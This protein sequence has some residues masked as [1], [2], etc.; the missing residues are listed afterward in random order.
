MIK[1][2][3]LSY[4]YLSSDF[5]YEICEIFSKVLGFRKLDAHNLTRY[6]NFEEE[7]LLFQQNQ[8]LAIPYQGLEYS[9]EDYRKRI[10]L[11]TETVNEDLLAGYEENRI[12]H[13]TENFFTKAFP[14]LEKL[15]GVAWINIGASHTTNLTASLYNQMVEKKL[16][17]DYTFQMV[18]IVCL[19]PYVDHA[20]K[21]TF[22]R[23]QES[24]NFIKNEKLNSIIKKISFIPILD[25]LETKKH[26]Y[27]SD[28]F[29]K[30]M[31][32][33]EISIVPSRE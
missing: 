27:Q 10:N 26:V 13:M 2:E 7:A 18:P 14:A 20:V 21:N 33:I 16:F 22:E 1:K 29:N 11:F 28:S 31:K 24:Q 5:I 19:S 23:I 17:K 30:L 9:L 15:G 6:I 8:E 12:A 25:I 32:T 3:N 4:P